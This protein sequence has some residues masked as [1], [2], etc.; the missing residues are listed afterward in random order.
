MLALRD[1]ISM[2]TDRCWDIRNNYF[3]PDYW[4][5]HVWPLYRKLASMFS[6]KLWLASPSTRAFHPTVIKT[7]TAFTESIDIGLIDDRYMDSEVKHFDALRP[8][9]D[10]LE[11]TLDTLQRKLLPDERAPRSR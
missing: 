2:K 10:H 1:E 8:F 3:D 5:E 9:Y 7:V 11:Q 6:E 4:Y